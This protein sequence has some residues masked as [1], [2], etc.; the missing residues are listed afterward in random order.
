MAR[1]LLAAAVVALSLV[2]P[3][4]A[5]YNLDPSDNISGA[6]FFDFW[7]FN[8]NADPTAGY[9]DYQ[10]R[11]NAQAKG[12]IGYNTAKN[13][14]FVGVDSTTVLTGSTARGRASVRLESRKQYTKGMFVAD[15]YHMPEE[16]CG[17][18]PAFWTVNAYDDYPKWGEIDIL[19]N[20]NEQSVA[21]NTL[22]TSPGFSI[23]GN[24]GA[25]RLASTE[26]VDS[27]NCDDT[28][29]SSAYGSQSLNQ[30]CSA[31]NTAAGAYGKAFNANGGGVVVMEWTSN[32]I[33]MW[34][35]PPG[36]VPQSLL[37]GKP[38]T[39]TF[40]TPQFDTEGGTGTTA[41]HFAN[42]QIVFDT[43]FCG[44]Y[45][46]QDYFWQQTSCY[47]NNPTKYAKCKDYVAANPAAFA[48]AYWII[49]SVKV[50]KWT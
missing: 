49:N 30:G 1:S 36:K 9:V 45:A 8:A 22:H 43:T 34:N 12:L 7:Y 4:T 23:A 47:K 16:V 25:T 31:R 48:N 35:F 40:G 2:A 50:Y 42:H 27:Y 3:S 21:L 13:R 11:A 46:G 33:K 15:L 39:T 19:E 6:N 38:D 44:N 41:D 28:A 18:W 37:D 5:V 32:F 24:H 14:A 29:T 17:I 26:I 10:T 20:I